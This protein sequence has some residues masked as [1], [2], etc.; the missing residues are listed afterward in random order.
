MMAASQ[1]SS[2]LLLAKPPL[3]ADSEKPS[4]TSP[5]GKVLIVCPPRWEEDTD[6]TGPPPPCACVDDDVDAGDVCD[7]ACAQAA[8]E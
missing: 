5:L 3:D 4:W 8:R 1:S 7:A 2:L 6:W